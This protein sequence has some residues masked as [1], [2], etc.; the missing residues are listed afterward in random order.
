MLIGASFF[1]RYIVKLDYPNCRMSILGFDILKHFIVTLH[2]K[3]GRGHLA[4]P[5]P[6]TQ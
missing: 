1:N 5:S 6:F 2:Y 4:I 3:N